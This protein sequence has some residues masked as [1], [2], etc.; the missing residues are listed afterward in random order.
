MGN[1]NVAIKEYPS[2]GGHAP[3]LFFQ[4]VIM[5]K[6]NFI[7]TTFAVFLFFLISNNFAFA[8]WPNQGGMY[9]GYHMMGANMGWVM[10]LFWGIILGAL[11]LIIRWIVSLSKEDTRYSGVQ[12]SALEILKE[13]FAKGEIDI[14]EF[15]SKKQVITD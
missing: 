10:I 9:G 11:I 15:E 2:S 7:K 3:E 6:N 8:G 14:A 1:P 4:E 5:S 12:D 13:R